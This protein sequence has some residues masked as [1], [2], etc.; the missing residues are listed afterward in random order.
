MRKLVVIP[1]HNEE[2]NIRTVIHSVKRL[3]PDIKIVVVN[4]GSTDGT[5]MAA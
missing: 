2:Q 4:D 1:A 5:S 3:H